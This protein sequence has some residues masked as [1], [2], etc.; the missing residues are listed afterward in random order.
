M[1][2]GKRKETHDMWKNAENVN[3]VRE[4]ENQNSIWRKESITN[5]E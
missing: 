1:D 4:E 3:K 5:I 2:R